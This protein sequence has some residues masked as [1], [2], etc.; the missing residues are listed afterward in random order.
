MKTLYQDCNFISIV[1]TV[2]LFHS[3][4]HTF[5]IF[6]LGFENK[7]LKL[8]TISTLLSDCPDFHLLAQFYS[9]SCVIRSI[10]L[11]NRIP[12]IWY[13]RLN[14]CR[15]MLG[16]LL[17]GQKTETMDCRAAGTSFITTNNTYRSMP[18]PCSLRLCAVGVGHKVSIFRCPIRSFMKLFL[19]WVWF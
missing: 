9:S 1:Q 10:L 15:T 7:L 14:N 6:T 2:S 12:Y 18:T 19:L 8:Q 11:S 5:L 4:N 17:P 3:T 13:L 16:W